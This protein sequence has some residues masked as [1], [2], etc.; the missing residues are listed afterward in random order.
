LWMILASAGS[1]SLSLPLIPIFL[2]L[3][4][5]PMFWRLA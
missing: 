1:F 3:S 5:M 2:G 4:H